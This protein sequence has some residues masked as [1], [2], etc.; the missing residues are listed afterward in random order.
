M[1]TRLIQGKAYG[2]SPAT[3]ADLEQITNI[4]NQGTGTANANFEPV[5]LENRQAW[6][7][8]HGD[9]RPI[10]V[11]KDGE[12]VVGFASLSDLYDRPA[13]MYSTEISI[14]VDGAYHGKGLGAF[15]LAEMMERARVLGIANV[16][17]LIFGHNTPSLA[18]FAKFGFETWGVL[19]KV[20]LSEGVMSDVVILGWAVKK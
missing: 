5:S 2:V 19:P 14:Y 6:F 7:L 12:R 15:L 1:N 3:L 9:T 4:Y 17:A 13:Y 10:V 11:V 8:S 20:C 16:V 18:L